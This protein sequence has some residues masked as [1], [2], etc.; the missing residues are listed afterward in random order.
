MEREVSL[1]KMSPIGQIPA[2]EEVAVKYATRARYAS[3]A[4]S[5][6]LL[7]LKRLVKLELHGPIPE[8][9]GELRSL[10]TLI[11]RKP[12]APT[13]PASITALRHLSGLFVDGMGLASLEHVAE[14]PALQTIT[15][16]R[17]PIAE[18]A[19]AIDATIAKIPGAKRLGMMPGIQIART[20]PPAP[21]DKA[22]LAA[23]LRDDTLADKSD[24]RGVDLAGET[25]EDLY[26]THDLR[27][28][29][30][31]GTTWRGCDFESGSFAGADLTGATF[32]DCYFAQLYRDD[33]NLGNIRAEGVTFRGCGGT[34]QLEGAELRDAKLLEMDS[35][36]VLKLA[37]AK[38]H[39]A[40]FELS[41][42]SE[43]E[44]QCSAKGAELRGAKIRIDVTPRRR[45]EIEQK[46]TS[47]F[48]WK[49]T[50]FDGAVT[51]ATTELVYVALRPEKEKPAKKPKAKAAKGA[52]DLN[53]PAARSLGQLWASNAGLWLLAADASVA[54]RW[55]GAVDSNDP[56]DDFQRALA[57][58]DGALAIGDGEGLVIEIG[59]N[60]W[61]HVWEVDGGIAL[62][63]VNMQ[64]DD[65]AQ[66]AREL[67]ARVA[68]W[69]SKTKPKAL[70]QLEITSGALALMLPYRDGA[71]TDAQRRRAQTE[72]VGDDEDRLLLALPNGTYKLWEQP[73]G[74]TPAYED[75]VGWYGSCYRL[76][77]S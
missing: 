54:Q 21:R 62:L 15:F 14:L 57:I 33:G 40:T 77:R 55:R 46:P 35:D 64:L 42:C 67:A 7:K 72:P 26:V 37:G 75:E 36:V 48:K 34:L 73:F 52:V 25:F 49:E 44:H 58:G 29:S 3:S 19:A 2:S 16:G 6:E 45:A 31:A 47:R 50:H 65:R 13:L 1:M 4:G 69:Q 43:K 41:F 66:L 28:A 32:E 51:D 56:A 68:Q 22:T 5:R 61:T 17:T 12:T 70:G 38:A 53:G 76:L 23:A 9:I 27:G 71:F 59:D 10:R 11:C 39:G 30:L 20:A 18:D 74:P 24:L 60:A 63:D 8:W